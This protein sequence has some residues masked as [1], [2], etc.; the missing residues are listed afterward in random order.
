M[1][2]IISFPDR[3]PWGK[4]SWRGNA[5]GHV[6]KS[7]FEQLQ[8]RTFC[9]PMVGS[10]TSVEVAKEMNIEAFGLDLHMG[11]NAIKD[12]IGQRIGKQV[13]LCVSHPPYGAMIQYSGV[14]WGNTPHPDDLSRCIDDEDFHQKMQLVLLNQREATTPGGFY[15]ALIG[16]YRK[17]GLY[18]SYQAEMI[19]RMPRDELAGVIIKAQHNCVSDSRTYG[20]MTMPRI[21]HEYLVL[22]Q[23]KARPMLILL[24]DMARSAHDRL[25]GTWK[26]IVKLVLVHLGGSSELARIYEAVMESAPSRMAQNPNWKAKVR[27]VLNSNTEF[28]SSERGIWSLAG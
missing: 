2:S 16:D 20:R 13:D 28:A 4:S 19:A 11:F 22:W 14:V 27:Q 15:G 26:N 21:M 1:N 9:D 7:L 6:Y 12:D 23:K 10:G 25:Q 3:G 8:P 18:T 24:S 17:G 5:S